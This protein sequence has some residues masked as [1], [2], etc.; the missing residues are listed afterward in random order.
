[1]SEL[2]DLF[3]DYTFRT[4]LLGTMG[5]GAVSGALGCF[6]Y[7]RKQSLIG[8][9]VS[10]SSLLGIMAFFIVS[11]WITGEGNKS[12]Y[13][14]IPGALVSGIAALLLTQWIVKNTRVREDSGLGTML[15]IFFGTGIFLLRYVQR[16]QPVIPG[17]KALGNFLFGMATAMTQADLIMI[18]VIG[19]VSI[20]FMVAM[21]NQLK[22]FTFD[23]LFSHCLGFKTRLLDVLLIVLMVNGIVIGIQCVGVVLM[24]ALLVTPAAAA[25]QWTNS[26]G[27]MVLLAALIGGF[28]AATGSIVS[29]LVRHIPTGP[30]IV[31]V[32]VVLFLV[33]ILFAPRRGILAAIASRKT[34]SRLSSTNTEATI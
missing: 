25:R 17:R 20:A 9:V 11:Y 18:A 6:A 8:D 27:T 34:A 32:G 7:L 2:Y 33:S 3:T 15:A 5:I 24:V 28:S 29:G 31:I 19:V 16:V 23:P 21:W 26:L 4:V 10:H 14:L 30:V 22:V 13:V 1:M 12:L